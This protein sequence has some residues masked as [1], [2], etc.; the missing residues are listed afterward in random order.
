M[1]HAWP[2]IQPASRRA[3]CHEWNWKLSNLSSADA[4]LSCCDLRSCNW[5]MMNKMQRTVDFFDV[6][7]RYRPNSRSDL[8]PFFMWP[9]VTNQMDF[10]SDK[11]HKV[12][13]YKLALTVFTLPPSKST[14]MIVK[15]QKTK[16]MVHSE[17]F[18]FFTELPVL[19]I[20]LKKSK[21]KKVS[22]SSLTSVLHMQLT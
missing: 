22:L 16:S 21:K 10:R 11:M 6:I 18:F 17:L 3:N 1:L 7:E 13:R 4:A 14:D 19:R 20:V 2:R 9:K 15:G 5:L 12:T 8:Y